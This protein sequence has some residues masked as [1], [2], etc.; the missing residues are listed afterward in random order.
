MEVAKSTRI[1]VYRKVE[2]AAGSHFHIH[3]LNGKD[4]VLQNVTIP[5]RHDGYSIDILI[6]GSVTQ[7]VDF[8]QDTITAPAVMLLEPDQVHQHDI[9]ADCE[10][11]NIYF[12]AD[13]LV[14]ETMGVV[15]CWQCVFTS[16]GVLKLNDQQMEEI[17][18]YF[19]LMETEFKS[20]KIRKEAM[21]RNLLSAFII[22]CGRI[23]QPAELMLN[24]ESAQHT[25]ARQF[26]MLV[27]MHFREK[28]QVSDYAEMMFV[29]PGHLNDTVKAILERSAKQVIDAKRIMEA[30]RLL[31]WGQH[32][33]KEICWQLKFEDD[34]Y[35]NRFFKKHTGHTPAV[36]QKGIRESATGVSQFVL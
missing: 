24:N 26:K 7:T 12:T 30:K 35:F 23:A 1:P 3:R 25:M 5:H 29:T 16:S 32:S 8:K 17:M 18:S 20:D 15:S 4:P 34:A 22:A 2:H 11:I 33:I 14:Q 19:R 28:V 21:L 31:Y 27:D 9:N 10:M 6:K 36:F 13:F